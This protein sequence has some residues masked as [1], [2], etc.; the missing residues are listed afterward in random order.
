MLDLCAKYRPVFSL[1]RSELGKCTTH[2]ATFPLP[3]NTKPVSRRPYRAN[4]RAE[5]VINKC[6]KDMLTDGIIEE[7]PSPWGSPVTIVARKDGQPRFCV[8]YRTTLNKLLIRKT[9]PMANMEAN[10][11]SVG[12]AQFISVADVQSAYWQIPV[13][14]EDVERT[15]F[16]LPTKANTVTSVCR[17]E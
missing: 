13:S 6:V 4:P 5:A 8:D 15:A 11:D 16:L 2:E 7:L 12:S 10:L 3:P 1:N 17:L 14:S 9:W